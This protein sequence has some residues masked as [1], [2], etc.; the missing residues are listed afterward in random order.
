MH[1]TQ[2]WHLDLGAH[3]VGP[4]SVRFRVWA[5]YARTVS[6]RIEGMDPASP[7]REPIPML[8]R[9]FGYYEATISGLTHGT[10]YRYLLDGKQERPDPASRAQPDGVHGPSALIDPDRFL[11]SDQNWTDLPLRD[12]IIYELHVGTFT[13]EGTFQGIIPFLDYLRNDLGI[14]AIEL[15]PV[16]QFPGAR[17]WGY[18]G[19]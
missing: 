11:W 10:R 14:T 16:A 7:L 5:P 9:E 12:L 3:L 6:V 15:M 18:D 2:P 1:Q 13:A 19:V 17:N 4:S 8:K